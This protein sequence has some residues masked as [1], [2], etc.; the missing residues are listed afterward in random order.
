MLPR[1]DVKVMGKCQTLR[2]ESVIFSMTLCQSMRNSPYWLDMSS[3]ILQR[4]A[5]EF[6]Q[7][8][9]ERLEMSGAAQNNFAFSDFVYSVWYNYDV[10]VK[11]HMSQTQIVGKSSYPSN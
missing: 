4:A 10:V 6:N 3:K 1:L 7:M 11:G 8:S 5:A 2:V 9:A